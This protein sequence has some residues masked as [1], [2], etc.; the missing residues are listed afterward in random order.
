MIRRVNCEE[1]GRREKEREKC[2]DNRL[3]FLSEIILIINS[4]IKLK[5]LYEPG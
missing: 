4:K 3:M 5:A 2:I 1:D